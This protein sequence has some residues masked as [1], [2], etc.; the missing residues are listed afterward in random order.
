MRRW[1]IL[2]FSVVLP[3]A[4]GQEN[5]PIQRKRRDSISV[6]GP[7]GEHNSKPSLEFWE[8]QD[9]FPKQMYQ[10]NLGRLLKKSSKK[11]KNSDDMSHKLEAVR[12]DDMSH[13]LE[14]VRNDDMSMSMDFGESGECE[15]LPQNQAVLNLLSMNVNESTLQSP[16]TSQGKAYRWMTTFKRTLDPCGAPSKTLQLYALSVLYFATGGSNWTK[17]EGWMQNENYCT[18]YGVT[19][20]LDDKVFELM[21]G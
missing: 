8:D 21:L 15:A 11:K 18:W 6:T 7:R 5:A 17:K 14:A 9:S 20:D 16:S 4:F 3:L 10:A 19:C 13:M 2:H 1:K 12:N